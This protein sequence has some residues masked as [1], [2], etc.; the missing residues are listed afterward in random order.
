VRLGYRQY[1]VFANYDV[2][3]LFKEEALA[4]DIFP[5]TFG[6]TLFSF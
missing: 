2:T 6:F 1:Q 3:P 5:F 4:P